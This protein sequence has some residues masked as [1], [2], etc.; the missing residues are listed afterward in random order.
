[1]F[2]LL[3]KLQERTFKSGHYY[4]TQF[5][6]KVKITLKI[7]QSSLTIDLRMLIMSLE[8]Q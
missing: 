1:L 4:L 8:Y 2:A 5:Y 7:R 6:P 3:S